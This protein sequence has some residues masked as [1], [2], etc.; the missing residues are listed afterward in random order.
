MRS[1]RG[2]CHG[3]LIVL[4]VL[5]PPE[6]EQ[7]MNLA[8]TY[9]FTLLSTFYHT[10]FVSLTTFSTFL[11]HTMNTRLER[12]RTQSNLVLKFAE[13]E[14]NFLYYALRSHCGLLHNLFFTPLSAEKYTGLTGTLAMH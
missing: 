3:F 8:S 2:E 11:I 6:T 10:W 7:M 5:D 14:L 13:T 12:K 1:Q 4:F 9:I